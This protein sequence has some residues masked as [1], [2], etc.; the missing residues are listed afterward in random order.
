MKIFSF[1]FQPKKSKEQLSLKIKELIG[2]WPVNNRLFTEAITHK[3]IDS[4]CNYERLEF[5]GDA[6]IDST[7][8]KYLFKTYSNLSEGELTQLRAKIVSRKN[9]NKIGESLKLNQIIISAFGSKELPENMYGNVIEALVGAIYIDGGQIAAE[10]FVTKNL[11]DSL[12][13]EDLNRVDNFKGKLLE[14][15]NQKIKTIQFV[16]VEDGY[17]FKSIVKI[18]GEQIAEGKGKTKKEAEQEGAQIAIQILNI[19]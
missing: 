16:T 9:L 6:I 11:V 7:V 15:G 13:E 4:K 10:T 5:L 2:Y 19:I 18:E 14:W 1:L 8:S 3:S 12:A 17:N